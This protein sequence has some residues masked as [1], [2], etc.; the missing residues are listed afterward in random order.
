M[1]LFILRYWRS[2][3]FSFA[4]LYTAKLNVWSSQGH[5]SN[6]NVLNITCFF[7]F[8]FLSSRT[9]LLDFKRKTPRIDKLP[10]QAA[11]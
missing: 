9:V 10:I 1:W 2:S 4:E 11:A 7:L 6:N 5:G 8:G 3:F